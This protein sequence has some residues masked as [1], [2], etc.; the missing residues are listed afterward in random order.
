[1]EKS[2]RKIILAV[3]GASGSV[4]ALKLLDFLRKIKDPPAE[5]AVIFS[6]NGKEIW[7]YENGRDYEAF[8][9]EKEYDSRDFH[10]PFASGS[11]DYDT[12]IICPASMGILGRIAS[13]SS[14]DLIARAAD[15]M[16]KEKRKLIVVPRET[17]YNLVHV[18]NM[19]TILLAGGIVCP[20]SPSFY[21][22]PGNIDDLVMTVVERIVSLAGFDAPLHRWM[23]NG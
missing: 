3:T 1:M 10:A 14:D 2:E 22:R 21:S 11:S 12:M 6:D 19:E 8:P 18:R 15:V 23:K 13:G 4:Y 17:P 5:T 7:K 20:A 16:L 9:P